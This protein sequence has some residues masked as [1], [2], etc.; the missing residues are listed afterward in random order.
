[1]DT[2][3]MQNSSMWLGFVAVVLFPLALGATLC[4]VLWVFKK[5]LKSRKSALVATLTLLPVSLPVLL[6]FVNLEAQH[7]GLPVWEVLTFQ[8]LDMTQLGVME[9]LFGRLL[10]VG[11]GWLGGWLLWR[12]IYKD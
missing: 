8:H 4:I 10:I 11:S 5:G 9:G 1:M 12:A 2:L 3:S 7:L 6:Y